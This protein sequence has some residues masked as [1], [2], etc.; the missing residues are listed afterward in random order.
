MA[1]KISIFG[2]GKLGSCM[3]AAIADRG[4]RV[5]GV[6]I[7]EE[8]I[9]AVNNGIPPVVEPG[10]EELFTRNQ[11]RLRATGS[12]QEAVE[13]SSLSF[14]IVPTPSRIDG[15]FSLNYAAE[16]FHAIGRA[17]REK[18]DYHIVVLTST[19]LPG[20]MRYGLLPILENTSGK[21]SGKEF[22]LCYSPLFIALGSVINNFLYPDLTLIGEY[23]RRSGKILEKFY[24]SV[25]QNGSPC[26]RMS[27]ENAEITKIALNTFVTTKIAF[28]NMLSDLCQNIP[29]GDI[30][31]VTDALGIDSRIGPKYLRGGLGYGGP[32]FPRDNKALSFTAKQVGV[33][34]ALADIT[35]AMNRERPIRL[36]E[37]FQELFPPG[38]RIAV[39]GLTYKPETPVLDESQSIMLC[40]ILI[41]KGFKVIAY[42][43]MVAAG[44]Q[45]IPS[46]LELAVSL[47]SCLKGAQG[48]FVATTDLDAMNF[49]P[50]HLYGAKDRP[51]VVIDCWRVLKNKLADNPHIIYLSL[52]NASHEN[53]NELRL[54][55]IWRKNMQN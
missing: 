55:K 3:A 4:H 16:A 43:P 27:L 10:L 38:A 42:D 8:T 44:T 47:E 33:N 28:A 45:T 54:Q 36:L 30:D 2:L 32:C 23:D 46:G 12:Y 37:K 49:E 9:K 22:G 26:K 7:C 48:V 21:R 39:L 1:Q 13:S 20:S 25:I 29:G 31:T 11:K 18:A 51:V 24:A 6:D 53:N 41:A 15:S 14:V 5:I 34:T 40:E 35:D 52:G 50:S 17:L 19:V